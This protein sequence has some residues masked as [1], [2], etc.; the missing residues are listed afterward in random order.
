MERGYRRALRN[1]LDAINASFKE[2]RSGRSMERLRGVVNDEV[3][4]LVSNIETIGNITR[5]VDE[6]LDRQEQ[7]IQDKE[8]KEED[9]MDRQE[10]ALQEEEDEEED[11]LDRQ[12]QE[13]EQAIQDM[14]DEAK[15]ELDKITRCM[16]MNLGRMQKLYKQRNDLE[17]VDKM[18][19]EWVSDAEDEEEMEIRSFEMDK[20]LKYIAY[21]QKLLVHEHRDIFEFQ[22]RLLERKRNYIVSCGQQQPRW[23]AL[24][25]KTDSELT[26]LKTLYD[27]YECVLRHCGPEM[28]NSSSSTNLDMT[29]SSSSSSS[30]DN[31]DDRSPSTNLVL[32]IKSKHREAKR[33]G[34]LAKYSLVQRNS[35]SHLRYSPSSRCSSPQRYS[36]SHLRYSP[37]RCS[38]PQRYSPTS[39]GY[40]L[41][42]RLSPQRYSPTFPRYLPSR[43]LSSTSLELTRGPSLRPLAS[44]KSPKRYN[45]CN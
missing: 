36:P 45:T 32:G 43:R 20:H 17:L 26:E 19:I 8:N 31:D 33:D 23:K 10:Q 11:E 39:P 13:A 22:R 27:R 18:M 21:E 25:E 9:E 7:A 41:S 4:R 24:L 14:E 15:M 44:L 3:I 38:S 6:E 2:F 42:R 28:E 29:F 40:S 5:D 12:S 37:S 16:D 35:P 1:T 34:S 30:S